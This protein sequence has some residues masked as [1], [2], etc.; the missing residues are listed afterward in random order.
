MTYVLVQWVSENK[1]DVYPIS[2]IEDAA[3]GYRLYTDKKSIGELR[4]TVNTHSDEGSDSEEKLSQL[5]KEN[6]DIKEENKRLK[7]A[8]E[9]TQN[10]RESYR[11]VKK[12]KA[13]IEKV[14]NA[15]REVVRPVLVDIGSGVM[16]EELQLDNLERGCP[17]NPG[18]FARGLLR[19]LFTPDELKGKSLFG[20]KC[21][22]KKDLEA[23]EA[24]NPVRVK[25]VIDGKPSTPTLDYLDP[26][27]KVHLQRVTFENMDV[28]LERRVSLDAETVFGK[29]T[30]RGRRGYYFELNSLFGRFLRTLGYSLRLRATRLRLT[31]PADSAKRTRTSHMVL[32]VELAHGDQYI[33]DVIMVMCGLHRGLPVAGDATPFR[34]YDLDWLDFGTLHWYSSTHPDSLMPRLLFGRLPIAPRR[35]LLGATYERPLRA[36]VADRLNLSTADVEA[37]LRIRLR[38]LLEDLRLGQNLFLKKRVWPGA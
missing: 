1:W 7:R 3:V 2:C 12:L 32:L 9:E 14:E 4:G 30:G 29:V 25:A 11:M 20:R 22:A 10:Y 37:P 31:T 27:I 6:R 26:L 8:L 28:L 35:R 24:L 23:K 33:V 18:K 38:E 15:E 19:I 34:P 13:I 36:L 16:V 5:E 21:N 17:G